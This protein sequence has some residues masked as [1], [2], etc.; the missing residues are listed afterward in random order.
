MAKKTAAP[1]KTPPVDASIEDIQV[2]RVPIDSVRPDP[3]NAN[4]HPQ[5]NIE[6]IMRSLK[7]FGQRVPIVTNADGEIKKGSGTW[8]AAKKLKWTTIQITRSNLS[9]TELKAYAI[10]DNRA[11]DLSEWDWEILAEQL[12]EMAGQGVDTEDLGYTEEEYEEILASIQEDLD[13]DEDDEDPET[14]HVEFDATTN[15]SHVR[16][17]QLFLDLKTYPE[18]TRLVEALSEKL[19]TKNHTDT[20]MECLRRASV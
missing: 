11:S 18:F 7:R 14:K 15:E 8:L 16:M 13:D 3:Q 5:R 12:A 1:A 19:G 6:A 17:V 10:A 4:T 20:V 9:P 2:E